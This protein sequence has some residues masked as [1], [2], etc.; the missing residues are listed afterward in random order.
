[1]V[2]KYGTGQDPYCYKDTDILI[3]K[4]NIRDGEILQEAEREITTVSL[5]GISFSLPPYNLE[6]Y[7]KIHF[8][9]FSSIYNWAGEIRSIDISKQDTRFCTHS[10]IEAEAH[11]LFDSLEKRDYLVNDDEYNNFISSLAELYADLN[12]IHPFRDGNGRVQ[13]I[14]FEHIALNCEYVFDWSVASTDEWT[15]ANIHG[16]NCNFAPLEKIFHLALKKIT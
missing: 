3:N 8:I 7:Q 10:R 5:K 15:L 2:D 1:M 14:L 9:L 11:K 16:V 12:M 6:Y 4:F 13:R